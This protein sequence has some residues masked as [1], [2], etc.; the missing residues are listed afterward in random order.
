MQRLFARLAALGAVTA[1]PGRVRIIAQADFAAH[2]G[3]DTE[4]HGADAAETI[5]AAAGAALAERTRG[6]TVVALVGAEPA[7]AYAWATVAALAAPVLV[8]LVGA[9]TAELALWRAV[10]W[11]VVDDDVALPLTRPSV[12]PVAVVRAPPSAPVVR[13]WS[14]VRLPTLGDWQRA[15]HAD[16]DSA[17]AALAAR[18]PR[19]LL[20]HAHTPWATAPVSPAT[21][22]A[23]AAH[24]AE[25]R[26]L[27]WRLP[28]GVDLLGWLPALRAIGQRRLA[29]TVLMAAD[30]AL[31]L[32]HWRALPGWWVAAP[33]E[34]GETIAVLARALASEDAVAIVLPRPQ[35]VPAWPVDADHEPGSGR[36]FGDPPAAR[37]TIVCAGESTAAALAA[38][39][40]LG[41][42]QL[43]VAVLQC[44]S[45][46][47]LPVGELAVASQRGP[48]VVVDAGDAASGLAVAVAAELPGSAGHGVAAWRGT[49]PG[50]ADIAA[51]VRRALGI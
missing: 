39:A 10:G 16:L 38:R 35:P 34:A 15:T 22:V 28:A 40:A 48:L 6:G 4:W 45:L 8:A 9:S 31:A 14:P 19:L 13:E 42:L 21:L 47:P 30:D 18:E 23:V 26:R 50:A 17:L 32:A 51:A 7:L 41:A 36:W 49:A 25:G 12:L 24:A 29:I 37:A 27:V 11:A 2:A 44:T 20:A 5:A 3:S 46:H 33:G 1:F 43:E